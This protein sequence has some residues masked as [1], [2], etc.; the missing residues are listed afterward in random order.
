MLVKETTHTGVTYQKRTKA[1]T[2]RYT[3]IK[4]DLLRKIM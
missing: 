4:A 1:G 3:V 2:A